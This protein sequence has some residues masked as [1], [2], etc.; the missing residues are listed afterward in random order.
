MTIQSSLDLTIAIPVLNEEGNIALCLESIGQDFARQIVVIDSCSSDRTVE[1]AKNYGVEIVQFK[2]NGRFPKKRNWFLR[3]YTPSTTWILFLDADEILTPEFCH[4][5]RRTLPNSTKSGFWLNYT[6]YFLGRRL[7][8]GY[9]L[10]KLAL[11]RL[12]VGE[13]EEIAE[14]RWS[15]FDMEIHEH[16]LIEGDVGMIKAPIDHRDNRGINHY[17]AK[18]KEYSSWEAFRIKEAFTNTT[19]IKKWTWKQRLKFYLVR[20]PLAGP[21]YFIGSYILMGG[22]FDGWRGFVFAKLKASYFN[23]IYCK[24]LEI[25]GQS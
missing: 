25:K 10:Q 24:T 8:G 17:V 22:C 3:N 16:P 6:I 12:G 11:F 20:T 1:I 9:P 23:Q 7:K 2:W 14:E 15:K 21:L 19:A 5:L 13:Y 18:H 4:E